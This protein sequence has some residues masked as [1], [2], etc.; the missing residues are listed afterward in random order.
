M[1]LVLQGTQTIWNIVFNFPSLLGINLKKRKNWIILTPSNSSLR[2]NQ[3]QWILKRTC[4][5]C[6]SR[7]AEEGRPRA[8]NPSKGWLPQA[9]P[10][11]LLW[12]VGSRLLPDTSQH[13]LHLTDKSIEEQRANC[14]ETHSMTHWAPRASHTCTLCDMTSWRVMCGGAED[15]QNET[16]PLL[17]V[18]KWQLCAAA[19]RFGLSI[20]FFLFFVFERSKSVA[21]RLKTSGSVWF[22]C[23]QVSLSGAAVGFFGIAVVREHNGSAQRISSTS[24]SIETA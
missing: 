10:L 16:T 9:R 7:Q 24:T 14:Q 2:W 21:P 18:V 4:I 8:N 15:L 22:S 19:M 5:L 23:L 20:F 3:R 11:F 1:Y 13:D 17:F 6:T 12:V